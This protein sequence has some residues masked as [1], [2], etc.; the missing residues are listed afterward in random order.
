[1]P[2]RGNRLTQ[3]SGK[4]VRPRP[5]ALDQSPLRTRGDGAG[6]A[7]PAARARGSGRIQGTLASNNK[8]QMPAGKWRRGKPPGLPSP[9][10]LA[11]T[12]RPIQVGIRRCTE[13]KGPQVMTPGKLDRRRFQ[14]E[15]EY[16]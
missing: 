5:S 10:I 8:W 4:V 2:A 12:Q 6:L 7:L 11:L 13:G 1:M 3:S 15:I 14:F 9:S 16:R